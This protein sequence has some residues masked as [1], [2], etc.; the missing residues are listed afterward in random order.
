MQRMMVLPNHDSQE[1]KTLTK[2]HKIQ[3]KKSLAFKEVL[4]SFKFSP[5]EAEQKS[6]E[7]FNPK[8]LNYSINVSYIDRNK[9]MKPIGK[10]G[11][12]GGGG[13]VVSRSSDPLKISVQFV[14][15]QKT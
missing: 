6:T 13:G 10:G 1:K 5:Q 15:Y 7:G 11:G 12:G 14:S 8:K 3:Q 4:V 9:E 2:N